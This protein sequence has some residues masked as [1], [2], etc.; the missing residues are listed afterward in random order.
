[1]NPAAN[2]SIF[3]VRFGHHHHA[4]PEGVGH[5]VVLAHQEAEK[6]TCMRTITFAKPFGN[7]DRKPRRGWHETGCNDDGVE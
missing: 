4:L 6:V 2:A 3:V 1:M 5:L 7:E